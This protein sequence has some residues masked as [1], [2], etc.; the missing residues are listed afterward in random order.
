MWLGSSYI[1]SPSSDPVPGL[2]I[3]PRCDVTEGNA[4]AMLPT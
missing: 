4:N 3:A 2:S 1:V